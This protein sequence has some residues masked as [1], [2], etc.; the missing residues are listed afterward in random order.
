MKWYRLN[1]STY[2]YYD[3][4]GKIQGKVCITISNIYTAYI[5]FG[6]QSK[7]KDIGTYIT[8]TDAKKAVENIWEE[9]QKALNEPAP[10][11][12]WG[13]KNLKF[14]LEYDE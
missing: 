9:F 12:F 11:G 8:D 10:G 14:Y 3:E 2:L 7:E 5:S 1:S 4:N 13:V 6:R